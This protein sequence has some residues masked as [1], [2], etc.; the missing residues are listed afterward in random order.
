MISETAAR[1]H[2]PDQDP[3]GQRLRIDGR[4]T[5]WVEI[6]GVV[7]DCVPSYGLERVPQVYEPFAQIPVNYLHFA[8]RTAG[9]PALIVPSLK[10]QIHAVDPNL[11]VPWAQTM[12]QTIGIISTLARQRFIIQ[13]L[14][15]FSGIALVIA[16]V[17]IYGVISY[18]VSRRTTEFGIRMALG[19]KVADVLRLVLGQGAGLVGLGLILGLAG[20]I[21][22]GRG[23][24]TMLY[25]T[26]AWDPVTLAIV[27]GLLA[28]TALLACWL[29]ARRAAKVDPMVA[30]R[31]E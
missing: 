15:L 5:E 28:G 24:E 22:V 11:A 29:P 19:A 18:S 2:F 13:L 7:T 6:V 14:G 31:C 20:S 26:S 12:T 27:V 25:Q 16:M 1:V 9:D 8:V 30:L 21:A 3:V 10:Q 23:I 17:G 4:F